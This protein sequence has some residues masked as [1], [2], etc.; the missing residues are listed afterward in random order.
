MSSYPHLM[1]KSLNI[2]E[3]RGAAARKKAMTETYLDTLEKEFKPEFSRLIDTEEPSS[4][5]LVGRMQIILYG[6][7]DPENEEIILPLELLS[8]AIDRHLVTGIL[9]ECD[10]NSQG[11]GPR[12]KLVDSI[13]KSYRQVLATLC[14]IKEVKSLREFLEQKITDDQLP[15]TSSRPKTEKRKSDGKLQAFIGQRWVH[16]SGW[17]VRDWTKFAKQQWSF[18]PPF[19]SRA[20]HDLDPE[21]HHYTFNA[22]DW[23]GL[24][25]FPADEDS[26]EA[27]S[28]QDSQ[29]SDGTEGED[30]GDGEGNEVAKVARVVGND[31]GQIYP[32]DYDQPRGAGGTV[33]K[34]KF[35]R[36]CHDF[37]SYKVLGNSL[38]ASH[39][40]TC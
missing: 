17:G 34:M 3:D 22:G 26:D 16:V 30:T 35:H 20:T 36:F 13:R 24:L 10:V 1:R 31:H 8:I 37:G 5:Q 6:Q 23:P 12:D 32:D 19:L 27:T 29:P 4:K 40:R 7:P 39:S 21:S 11:H 25:D 9:E 18:H 14:I 2:C 33:S 38:P 15:I 28:V